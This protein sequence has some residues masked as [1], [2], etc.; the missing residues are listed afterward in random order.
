MDIEVLRLLINQGLFFAIFVLFLYWF[1]TQY[2]PR[3]DNETKALLETIQMS[4]QR[5]IETLQTTFRDSIERLI[6]TTEHNSRET[7]S[8]IERIE[9]KIK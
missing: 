2:L 1:L 8:R 6:E 9:A 3:K 5:D 4:H 7:N